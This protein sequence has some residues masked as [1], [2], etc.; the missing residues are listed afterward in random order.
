MKTANMTTTMIN[1]TGKP[2]LDIIVND[3]NAAFA[4]KDK[5]ALLLIFNNVH[6][7]CVKGGEVAD[8]IT[9][10]QTFTQLKDAFVNVFG[11][12][13]KMMQ[14]KTRI[15]HRH[16]RAILFAKIF[17]NVTTRINEQVVPKSN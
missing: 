5:A 9:E 6:V 16:R 11:M 4:A 13:P 3:L 15:P 10:P 8:W 2:V 12:L 17:I 1:Y 7:E 14:L